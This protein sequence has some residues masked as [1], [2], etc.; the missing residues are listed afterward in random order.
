MD[1]V[2]DTAWFGCRMLRPC[3]WV[4]FLGSVLSVLIHESMEVG[5]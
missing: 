4:G 1:E 3:I 2:G 5:F